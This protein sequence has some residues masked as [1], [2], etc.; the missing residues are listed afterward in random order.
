MFASIGLI[1]ACRDERAPSY[2][3]IGGAA[4][5]IPNA[6]SSA[7]Q[8]VVFWA[9]WC[10]PCR[11]ETPA[12][13]ALAKTPPPGLTVVMLSHDPEMDPVT[14]FFTGPA[15]SALHLRLDVDKKTGDAFGVSVLPTSFLVVDGRLVAR[16]D[17]PRDWDDRG[18][19][20]LLE[21]LILEKGGSVSGPRNPPD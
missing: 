17:G 19:R 10:A 3:R 5:E 4:P 18:M 9:A 20:T 11:E 6:P 14:K 8:L 2:V 7:A 16:F 21:R 13:R 12:L 1:A 15:D